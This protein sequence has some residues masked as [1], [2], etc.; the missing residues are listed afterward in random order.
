M[1]IVNLVL[2][3][4]QIFLFFGANSEW[5]KFVFLKYLLLF[6]MIQRTTQWTRLNNIYVYL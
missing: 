5:D 4:G 1:I 3:M 6:G 2:W